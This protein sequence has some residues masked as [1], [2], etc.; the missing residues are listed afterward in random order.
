[1]SQSYQA[2]WFHEIIS[3]QKWNERICT[4]FLP[5]LAANKS[6][7]LEEAVKQAKHKKKL[8]AKHVKEIVSKLDTFLRRMDPAV[9]S[10]SKKN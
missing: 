3:T 1:V 8:I 9:L 6:A 5:L 10:R 4:E 7:L 2:Q